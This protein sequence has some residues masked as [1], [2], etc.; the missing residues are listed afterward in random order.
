MIILAFFSKNK[1]S[2]NPKNHEKSKG[3]HFT[4]N[5]RG[6]AKKQGPKM[7]TCNGKKTPLLYP[8]Y[9]VTSVVYSRDS[10]KHLFFHDF[11]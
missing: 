2:E 9:K 8:T 10:I 6:N 4:E 5:D 11:L 7:I 3:G 1:K